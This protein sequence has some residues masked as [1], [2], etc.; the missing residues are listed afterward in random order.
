MLVTQ[1]ERTLIS[2]TSNIRKA[3]D[4]RVSTVGK[5]IFHHTQ[6]YATV[7]IL[8]F[9]FNFEVLQDAHHFWTKKKLHGCYTA[10]YAVIYFQLPVH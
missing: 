4:Y 5:K 9:V 2:E 10:K 8:S 3:K 7:K 1:G 6:V